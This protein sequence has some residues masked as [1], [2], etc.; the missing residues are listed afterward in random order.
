MYTVNER[1]HSQY[2]YGAFNSIKW[3]KWQNVWDSTKINQFWKSWS[4]KRGNKYSSKNS[5]WS[6]IFY[7]VLWYSYLSFGKSNL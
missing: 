1:S 6:E 3:Q 7:I 4:K 2:I 5:E